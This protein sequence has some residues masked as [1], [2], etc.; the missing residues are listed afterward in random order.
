[1]A[2]LANRPG[3]CFNADESG[4]VLGGIITTDEMSQWT[5]REGGGWVKYVFCCGGLQTPRILLGIVRHQPDGIPGVGQ[6]T[7]AVTVNAQDI[8]ALVQPWVPGLAGDT[9]NVPGKGQPIS[10]LLSLIQA[11][12]AI[13]K[14]AQ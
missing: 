8:S 10:E 5:W 12:S 9:F 2:F 3:V 7:C 13:R 6:T 4:A 1:M 14:V 11:P